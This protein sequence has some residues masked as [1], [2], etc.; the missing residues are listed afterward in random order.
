[1]F[2]GTT[3]QTVIKISDVFPGVFLDDLVVFPLDEFGIDHQ[4]LIL[5]SQ[6]FQLVQNH[7]LP[8]F[9]LQVTLQD[10]LGNGILNSGRE[11]L[12]LIRADVDMVCINTFPPQFGDNMFIV[13]PKI[14]TN[15][16]NL[17]VLK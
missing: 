16:A 9:I 14:K 10:N 15:D 11:I 17:H 12:V 6:F 8:I 3:R 4:N 5:F 2:R 1:M 7:F 13:I